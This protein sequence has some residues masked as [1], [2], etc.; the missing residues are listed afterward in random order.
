MTPLLQLVDA[1]LESTDPVFSIVDDVDLAPDARRRPRCSAPSSRRSSSSTSRATCSSRP[2]CSR[3]SRRCSTQTGLLLS[4]HPPAARSRCCTIDARCYTRGVPTT[5][6]RL[7]ITE[8]DEVAAAL[9]VAAA[10]WPEVAS[11]RELLLRLVEQGRAVIEHERADETE[12]RR[13]RHPTARAAR[14]PASTSPAT[15]SGCATTGPRDRPRCQRADRAASMRDDA[16]HDA[17]RRAARRAR[18]IE[19][20]ACSPITLAEVLVGAGASCAGSTP[21]ARGRGARRPRDRT[22]RGRRAPSR[23]RCAPRPASS[24]RT[25]VFCWPRRSRGR[26]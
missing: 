13:R 9:D 16:Q 5:R 14:S 17:G 7:M 12:R 26:P 19:P 21:P 1:L 18:R 6:P 4:R 15:S 23:R 25:A 22:C 10:R 2:P 20:F 8:T 3:R 11:R 24:S